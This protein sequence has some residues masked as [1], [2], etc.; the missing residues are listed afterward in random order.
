MDTVSEM[1]RNLPSL[2]RE[3]K[4]PSRD[5]EGGQEKTKTV[6]KYTVGVFRINI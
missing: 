5:C 3:N 2:H 4:K 6:L 1:Y